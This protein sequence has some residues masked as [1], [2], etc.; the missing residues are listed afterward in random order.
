MMLRAKTLRRIT[1][2]IAFCAKAFNKL[3]IMPLSILLFKMKDRIVLNWIYKNYG[4]FIRNYKK[5]SQ[6]KPKFQFERLPIWVCWLQGEENAPLLVKKCIASIKSFLQALPSV[7]S[8]EYNEFSKNSK[9]MLSF[10]S[11]KIVSEQLQ[12]QL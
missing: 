5:S 11:P 3:K 8:A 6:L 4:D 9:N 2:K 1:D 7:D 10:F 12:E